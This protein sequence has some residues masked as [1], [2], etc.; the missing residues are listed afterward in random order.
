[1]RSDDLGFEL[2]PEVED[3]ELSEEYLEEMI[4][5]GLVNEPE[6]YG[7]DSFSE[8]YDH[9]EMF[10]EAS[11]DYDVLSLDYVTKWK[12]FV[13]SFDEAGGVIYNPENTDQYYTDK[14][15]LSAEDVE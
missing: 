8:M 7:F 1:M 9:F 6:E 3:I 10:V 5:Q 14:T 11:D 15:G 4:N 12:T 2:S 13:N